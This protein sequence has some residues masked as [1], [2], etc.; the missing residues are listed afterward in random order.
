MNLVKKNE[1]MLRT[2]GSVYE[3][4]HLTSL[5]DECN[6]SGLAVSI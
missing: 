1:I 4:K 2:S 5:G 3:S 6:E